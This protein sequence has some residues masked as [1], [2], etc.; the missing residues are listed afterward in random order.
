MEAKAGDNA[1][2]RATKHCRATL[3]HPMS[4]WRTTLRMTTSVMATLAVVMMVKHLYIRRRISL[5]L[6]LELMNDHLMV[7]WI[8]LV[9]VHAHEQTY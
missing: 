3:I 5:V 9:L 1:L 8:S 6:P 4:T 7:F 2:E